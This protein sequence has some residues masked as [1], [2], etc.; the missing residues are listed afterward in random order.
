[1]TLVKELREAIFDFTGTSPQ[2]ISNI[3][4]PFSITYSSILYCLRCIVARDF[5]LNQGC[6]NP[7]TILLPENSLLSPNEKCAVVGGNVLT[8]Q[9]ITDIVLSIFKV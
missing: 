6:L 8:S 2:I 9:R 5:P 7:I 4:A 3:N 1:M